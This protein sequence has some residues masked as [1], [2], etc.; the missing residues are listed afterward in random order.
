MWF[1]RKVQSG[2]KLGR[3]LGFPTLNCQVG[4]V[5]NHFSDGVYACEV[6]H[7]G[8]S[9]KGALHLGPKLGRRAKVL[10]IHLLN[11]NKSI[12]GKFIQ[13]KIGQK[14]RGPK[15]FKNLEELKQQISADIQELNRL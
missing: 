8:S 14:I 13:I 3:K 12:Y 9:Y 10:E 2:Q 5:A 6:M 4:T 1:R 11:F 7:D 15:S